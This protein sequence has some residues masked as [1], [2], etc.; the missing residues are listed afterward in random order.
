MVSAA[1]ATAE[2]RES[3][4]GER[5]IYWTWLPLV[6]IWLNRVEDGEFKVPAFELAN[7]VIGGLF[8]VIA[9]NFTVGAAYPT[10][11]AGDNTVT[12]LFGLNYMTLALSLSVVI[13]FYRFN[14][15]RR[16]FGRYVEE[17]LFLFICWALPILTLGT[18]AAFLLVAAA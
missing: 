7:M 10:L 14:F 8:A 5:I 9:L 18:S 17:Q 6:A 1:A 16:L 2:H 11:A 12:R 13:A 3:R 15:P 4:V